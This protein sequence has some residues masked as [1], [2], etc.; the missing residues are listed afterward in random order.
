MMSFVNQM[1]QLLFFVSD[2]VP[3]V[4]GCLD[5]QSV[6]LYAVA[7]DDLSIMSFD[8]KTF[9]LHVCEDINSSAIVSF[10]FVSGNIRTGE[11]SHSYLFMF[12][13]RTDHSSDKLKLIA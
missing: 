2:L 5:D 8:S 9:I 10:S 1:Q 3:Q 11:Q 6:K 4:L 7:S 12:A 13:V